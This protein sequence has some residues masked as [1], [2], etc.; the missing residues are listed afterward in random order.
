ME[1]NFNCL[2]CNTSFNNNAA[3]IRHQNDCNLGQHVIDEYKSGIS[4]NILIKKYHHNYIT[5]KRYLEQN[6]I[7]L[8]NNEEIT[9]IISANSKKTKLSDEAKRR[10]S[11]ARKKYFVDNPDKHPWKNTS[12]FK[13]KPCE[14]FKEVLNE[15]NIDYISE[16][17]P[18]DERAFSIDIFLPGYMIGI[19]IN[20]NQ[21]YTNNGSLK[22]YYQDRHEFIENLGYKLFELH[23]SLFFSRDKMIELINSIIENKPLFEFDYESYVLRKLNNKIEKKGYC[24][25]CNE[26][27]YFTAKKCIKCYAKSRRKTERPPV[28]V[29]LE[30]VKFLGYRGAGKKYSVSDTAI[31]KWLKE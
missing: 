14:N 5:I 13:S 3:R 30:D 9:K 19:E 27:I 22:T 15:L 20:G 25:V 6:G 2:K 11:E 1:I 23:Y 18:S 21:H 17:T 24:E 28:S 16:Y 26:Q 12:K 7:T 8:R 29:L 10:I 31:K 4:L